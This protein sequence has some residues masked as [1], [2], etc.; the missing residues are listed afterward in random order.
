LRSA[1]VP[2]VEDALRAVVPDRPLT[3]RERLSEHAKVIEHS[4]GVGDKTSDLKRSTAT[5]HRFAVKENNDVFPKVL[6]NWRQVFNGL[7]LE[8]GIQVAAVTHV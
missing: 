3:V 6:D 2:A 4:I 1:F 8:I 7:N 5:A